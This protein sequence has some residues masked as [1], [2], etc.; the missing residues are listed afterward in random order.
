[1][2]S[3]TGSPRHLGRELPLGGLRPSSVVAAH[4]S[5]EVA[6]G[7]RKAT[8][9]AFSL[10]GRF[11]EAPRF[12]AVDHASGNGT[13]YAALYGLRRLV[14]QGCTKTP[15]K[16]SE[17]AAIVNCGGLL[18]TQIRNGK[19]HKKKD[20]WVGSDFNLFGSS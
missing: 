2:Q 10:G 7:T 1:M 14:M 13:R 5:A 20:M 6:I 17:L 18:R 12:L 16:K 3:G 19:P 15:G 8:V 9:F 4:L 11:S